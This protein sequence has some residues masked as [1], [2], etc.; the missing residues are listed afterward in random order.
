M[1]QLLSKF[2]LKDP[3]KWYFWMLMAFICKGLFFIFLLSK[4]EI[5]SIPGFWGETSGDTNDYITSINNFM[6]TGSYSPDYRMPGYGLIYLPFALIFSKPM[7]YNFLILFQFTVAA[8]SVYPLALIAKYISKSSTIFY[9][10]FYL[11]I[12]STFCSI[13]D[14]SLLTESFATAFLIFSVFFFLKGTQ[15]RKKICYFLLSGIFLA[16]VISLRPVYAPLLVLYSLVL[17]V[18]I[19]KKQLQAS[20]YCV[21]CIVLPFVLCDTLWI[22]RNYK[23]HTEF[24]PLIKMYSPDIESSYKP[25]LI[26]FVQSWGGSEVWW[27]P[28]AEIRWFGIPQERIP[29]QRPIQNYNISLPDYIY[30]S[31]FN[32]DSLLLVKTLIT[33]YISVRNDSLNKAKASTLLSSIGTKLNL[34]TVS[35]KKEKPFLYY[36]TAPLILTRKFLINSGTC[37]LFDKPYNELSP[38]ESFFKLF[39]SLF[40]IF[41]LMFGLMGILLFARESIKLTPTSLVTGIILFTIIIHPVI[42]RKCETRYFVPA[43]P[44]MLL[45]AAY[46][47]NW[48]YNKLKTPGYSA[49][50]L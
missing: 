25:P 19:L 12:I 45:C 40:Y 7:A 44:F 4:Q 23:A 13:F 32:Y 47:L 39:F 5:N 38:A 48:I 8:F 20:W 2:F 1:T 18:G 14:S 24:I 41:I 26:N 16:W 21:S 46:S 29:G 34:Y 27:E 43:Y 28:S 36:V 11:Y 15:E 22:I 33:E 3:G 42:L 9:L 31:Q 6:A 10:T 35:I 49:V 30:T 50:E 17:L 37:N